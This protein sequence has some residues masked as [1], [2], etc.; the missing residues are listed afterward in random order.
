MMP[1]IREHGAAV[2]A[3]T[4]DEQGQARTAEWKVAVAERL[5]ED[6]TGNWGMRTERHHRRLPDVPDRHRPGGDPAGR[7]RDHRG[8]PR[9][10]APLPGRADHARRLQRLVRPQPGRPGRAEL[11]VPRRVR[12]GRARLGDRARV[13]DHADGADP[14]GAARGRPGPGLR[15]AAA[16]LRPAG[17]AAGAVRGR[18]RRV[19]QGRAGRR[20]GRAAAVGAAQAADHRRRAQRPRGRPG[21]GARGAAR[22]GDRQR[23]AA[24][25]HEDGRR[26]VRLRP[27]AAAVRA[28]V[29]RGDEG[30]GRLPGAA[31]GAGG[32]GRPGQD[33]ARHGQGRRARHRQ[34]PGRHHLVQ[35]RLRRRKHRHQAADLRDHLRRRGAPGRRHRD[36]RACW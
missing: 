36:V 10:Q 12:Q 30:R 25:R 34:E 20:A 11:G 2:V 5:I 7:A 4:I 14:G 29:R 9:A 31:H 6:L 1:L 35:Q 33:R 28:A 13:E 15:P 18:G 3:L 24:R 32:R 22:P 17:A 8:D 19:G 27:D 21:P 26:A 16:R 23:R